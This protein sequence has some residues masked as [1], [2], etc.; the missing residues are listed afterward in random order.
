VNLLVYGRTLKR[1]YGRTLKRPY[2][3]VPNSA[4][5]AVHLRA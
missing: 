1:P 5:S 4:F 3:R 2:G